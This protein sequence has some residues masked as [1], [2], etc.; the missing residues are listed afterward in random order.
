MSI[1]DTAKRYIEADDDL[2]PE[3]TAEMVE[4][5]EEAV[6]V[7]RQLRDHVRHHPKRRVFGLATRTLLTEADSALAP[8]G[9]GRD[10]E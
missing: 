6:R 7:L 1:L 3:L 5:T 4:M 9:V 2:D 10:P 8:F